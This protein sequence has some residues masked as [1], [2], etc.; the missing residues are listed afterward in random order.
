[1]S[2]VLNVEFFLATFTILGTVQYLWQYGT[3]KLDTGPVVTFDLRAYG[4]VCFSEASVYGATAYFWPAEILIWYKFWET[5]VQ[6]QRLFS[7]VQIR[8]HTVISRWNHRG[9]WQL[10]VPEIK[11]YRSRIAMNIARS[12]KYR[13]LKFLPISRPWIHATFKSLFPR[14][15]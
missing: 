12:L 6:G 10:L 11:I 15:I 1:M 9:P 5:N 4:A 7:L 8:G 2:R 14:D 3:G 13:F